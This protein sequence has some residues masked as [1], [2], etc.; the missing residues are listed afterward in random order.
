[1]GWVDDLPSPSVARCPAGAYLGPVS[2]LVGLC[3][4]HQVDRVLVAL[5]DWSERPL[6]EWL[7]DTPGAVRVSAVPSFSDLV[8]CRTAVDEFHG[9]AVIDL[10]ASPAGPVQRFAKRAIDVSV[11]GAL[12]FALLPAMA[13]VAFRIKRGSP[14]PVLF[15]QVR[16]GRDGHSFVM[17]KFRTMTLGADRTP[18]P[19]S[20][21]DGPVFK[22]KADPRVTAAGRILRRDSLDELPQLFN[23]LRGQM[24]LVGPRPLPPDESAAFFGWAARRLDVRPGMTGYWQVSGRNDLTFAE[25]QQLD[26]AY[27]ASWSLWWDLKILWQTPGA[28]LARRGA[29]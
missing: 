22:L 17:L 3:A 29:Y 28:V 5:D 13:V 6:V 7:R 21:M 27:A 18:R 2:A 10:T 1:V 4:D 12:L 9:L 8:T 16:V 14:G 26:H 19:A 25:L 11:S 23:V 20:D 24:S 15:R